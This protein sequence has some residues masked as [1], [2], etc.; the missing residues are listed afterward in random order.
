MRSR[1]GNETLIE[2]G[3]ESSKGLFQQT[4]EHTVKIFHGVAL[5]VGGFYMKLCYNVQFSE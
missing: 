1:L 2:D 5:E 3:I 4:K